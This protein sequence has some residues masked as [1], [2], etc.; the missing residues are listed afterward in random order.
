LAVAILRDLKGDINLDVPIEGDLS[1]PNYKLGKVIWQ[2][3]KNIIFKAVTSPYR[4]IADAVAVNEEDIRRIHFN[5]LDTAFSNKQVKNIEVLVKVLEKKPDLTISLVQYTDTEQEAE[6]YAM[7]ETMKRYRKLAG[8]LAPEP[9][10]DTTSKTS[11]DEEFRGAAFTAWLNLQA[12]PANISLPVQK[13]CLAVIGEQEA[14][15]AALKN[16]ELRNAKAKEH[17]LAAGA[18]LTKFNIYTEQREKIPATEPL[19][20][21]NIVFGMPSGATDQSSVSSAR[22]SVTVQ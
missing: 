12:G 4:I 15:Q 16:Q 2:V 22:D 8:S 14:Q 11:I 6:Q 9:E 13:K 5:Y 3:I 7:S 20:C 18:D 21:Y 10:R 1:D 17:L 19:P